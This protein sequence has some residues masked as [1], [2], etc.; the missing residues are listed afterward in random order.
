MNLSFGRSRVSLQGVYTEYRPSKQIKSSVYVAFFLVYT[1]A[2][3]NQRSAG[4][5]LINIPMDEE[6]IRS[7]DAAVIRSGLGNRSAFIR[8][9]IVEKLADMG[10]DIP[11]EVATAPSKIGKG[12]RPSH[13]TGVITY[14]PP[15]ISAAAMNEVTPQVAAVDK[16]ILDDDIARIRAAS[17][18]GQGVAGKVV[19]ARRSPREKG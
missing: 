8:D 1:P 6:F 11:T 2:V 12:G 19:P 4:Q 5:K 14:P 15:V 3:P 18:S 10:V 7:L 9:A 13:R 16:A 17:A